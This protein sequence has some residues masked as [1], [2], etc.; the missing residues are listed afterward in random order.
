MP[1]HRLLI[2]EL[3]SQRRPEARAVGD[4]RDPREAAMR[5]VTESG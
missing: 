3:L 1:S 2:I 5:S 4:G